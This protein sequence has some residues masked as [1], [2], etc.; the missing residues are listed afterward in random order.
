MGPAAL[1]ELRSSHSHY[2]AYSTDVF[3]EKLNAARRAGGGGWSAGGRS[4]GGGDSGGSSSKSI[5][6][7]GQ[8]VVDDP[9]WDDGDSDGNMGESSMRGRTVIID[10]ANIGL[11][12]EMAPLTLPPDDTS[13]TGEEEQLIT[14]ADEEL[15]AFQPRAPA[16][17]LLSDIRKSEDLE[18]QI[19]NSLPRVKDEPLEDTDVAS[20]LSR[21]AT[22]GA[23][24]TSGDSIIPME[25]IEQKDAKI[26]EEVK[27]K[28]PQIVKKEEVA[29]GFLSE[30]VCLDLQLVSLL[31][32]DLK[33]R[34]LLP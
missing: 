13:V 3:T 33:H 14:A 6:G 9:D 18:N 32:I 11:E 21:T 26:A 20:A 4:G 1:R 22:P 17:D 12:D 29:T 34:A 19:R 25:A 27:A 16:A 24:S 7:P 5:G 31:C 15:T 10:M 2:V 23:S 8:M 28:L 30:D